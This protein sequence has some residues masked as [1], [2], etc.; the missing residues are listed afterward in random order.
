MVILGAGDNWLQLSTVFAALYKTVITCDSLTE[1]VNVHGIQSLY[2]VMQFIVNICARYHSCILVVL[3]FL[4]SAGICINAHEHKE[5]LIA[6]TSSY[7]GLEPPLKNPLRK[8]TLN[9]VLLT[10]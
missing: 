4:T 2:C 9:N 10:L 7:H 3:V 6:M 1:H 5:I 8:I